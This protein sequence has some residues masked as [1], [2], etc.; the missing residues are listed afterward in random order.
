[1]GQVLAQEYCRSSAGQMSFAETN[2]RPLI[3][4]TVM[5]LWQE[6]KLKSSSSAAAEAQLTASQA[7]I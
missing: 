5:S 3:K 7:Q 1:M 4:T 2:Y 6:I